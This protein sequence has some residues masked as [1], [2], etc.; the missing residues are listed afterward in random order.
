MENKIWLLDLYDKREI[1]E[2]QRKMV[3]KNPYY[4][5]EP[6]PSPVI[7]KEIADFIVERSRQVCIARVYSDRQYFKKLCQFF[8][9][10]ST[11]E[12]SLRDKDIPV[13]LRQFKGWMLGRGLP[14]TIQR[15]Q[16]TGKFNTARAREIT[17][18]ERMLKFVLQR[19]QPEDTWELDKLDIEFRANPIKNYKT[20]NFTGIAQKP[21]REEVK[22]GIYLNLQGEAIACVQKEMTAIRRLSRYLKE[23]Y[24]K[25]QS[26]KDISREVI[27]EYLTYLKTEATETKHYHADL[28]RLRALLESIG[29]M[30]NYPHLCGLFLTREIP[31]APKAKFKVYSDAEL[32]R[33]NAAIVKM[34]EQIARLMII[35][36]M[37]GTR[38]SDTLT[39][40]P[41]C[42]YTKNGENIIRIRQMKTNTYEKPVS[43]ELASLIQKAADYTKE[44]YGDTPYIFVNEK[45]I[46]RPLQYSTVQ[47]KITRMIYEQ[48]LLDD[49]GKLFGFNTHMF[50]HYYAVKLTEMHLDDWTI[51]KLLGHNNLKNVKY[52]RKMSNQTLA[53]DTRKARN[54][55]SEIILC[56]LDGWEDEYEQ[57]RRNDCLQP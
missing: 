16:A 45:D 32:R 31:P 57:I 7:R 10:Y 22:K 56:N 20:I 48:N 30:C 25:V 51:A 5:L 40:E 50:R 46:S 4:D 23:K 27:E 8:Q 54:R 28:N 18:F 38:I 17:Y 6:I 9:I 44:R 42:V 14:L 3:G 37:L 11:P 33:L 2:S 41:G 24:P 39:L 21:L 36:Q 13:W 29:W 53:D 35:H 12:S 55:L 15:K 1:T 43:E 49:K 47:N 52:Y 19:E 34:D 26:A